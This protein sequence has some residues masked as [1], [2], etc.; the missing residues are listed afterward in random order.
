[1]GVLAG[2]QLPWM[3]E[4][5]RRSQRLLEALCIVFDSVLFAGLSVG[6]FRV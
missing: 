2:A 1:M 4:A 3:A 6:K 5:G